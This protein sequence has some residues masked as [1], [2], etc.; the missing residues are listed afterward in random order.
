MNFRGFRILFWFLKDIMENSAA[1]C[2]KKNSYKRRTAEEK[3]IFSSFIESTKT[4]QSAVFL[5]LVEIP[6]KSQEEH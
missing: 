3:A 1:K 2:E 6:C 4:V 5:Q